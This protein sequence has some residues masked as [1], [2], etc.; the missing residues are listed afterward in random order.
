MLI[1]AARGLLPDPGR[2][3]TSIAKLLDVSPRHPLPPHPIPDLR[4]LRADAVPAWRGGRRE[5]MAD[6]PDQAY[7]WGRPT[8]PP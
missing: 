1:R 6:K 8:S 3:I 4:E 7:D 2:A 5:L